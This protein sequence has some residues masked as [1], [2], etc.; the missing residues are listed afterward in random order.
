MTIPVVEIAILLI[1]LIAPLFAGTKHK[2]RA[3]YRRPDKK[4]DLSDFE[5]D[6]AG[7]LRN[8]KK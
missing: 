7:K 6:G 3:G 4:E 5:I 8:L 1:I 2:Q